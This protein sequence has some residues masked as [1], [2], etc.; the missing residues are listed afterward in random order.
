[1]QST[2]G[3]CPRRDRSDCAPAATDAA[4]GRCVSPA[5][6]GPVDRAPAVC[7]DAGAIITTAALA[8]GRTNPA[9]VSPKVDPGQRRPIT[10]RRA[11]TADGQ[12]ANGSAQLRGPAG[13]E[14]GQTLR[15]PENLCRG[16]RTDRSDALRPLRRKSEAVA[17]TP[18]R[19]GQG[20]KCPRPVSSST[21]IWKK[22]ARCP[23][24]NG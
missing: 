3:L 22:Q 4:G 21:R 11:P 5:T 14:L 1:M 6:A 9:G 20:P 18:A 8:P 13:C 12:S 2:P 24:T 23:E 15:R 16:S 10:L 7:R 19:T 17:S